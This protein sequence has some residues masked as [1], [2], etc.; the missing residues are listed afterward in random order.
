MTKELPVMIPVCEECQT[1]SLTVE[2]SAI[3]DEEENNWLL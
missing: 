1:Q 3:W 2:A